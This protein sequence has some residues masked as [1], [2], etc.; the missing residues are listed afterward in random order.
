MARNPNQLIGICFFKDFYRGVGPAG[1]EG[2]QASR[3]L[4]CWSSLQVTRLQN[5]LRLLSVG[6]EDGVVGG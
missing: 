6:H 4:S 3:S 5:L 2:V 1:I